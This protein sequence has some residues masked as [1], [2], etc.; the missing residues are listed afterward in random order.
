MLGVVSAYGFDSQHAG[1]I[2]LI[3]ELPLNQTAGFVPDS[4]QPLVLW[5]EKWITNPIRADN[6]K[7][8]RDSGADEHHLFI[9]LAGYGGVRFHVT[10]I[11]TRADSPIPVTSP[12]LPE[13]VTHVWVMSTWSQGDGL[14]WS[15]G[16]GWKRFDKMINSRLTAT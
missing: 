16:G 15:P 4:G 11:L 8:L 14:R 13:D 3:P 12:A 1:T 5:L 7:K 9:I 2:D 6:L 10:D